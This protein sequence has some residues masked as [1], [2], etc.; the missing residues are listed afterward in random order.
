MCFKGTCETAQPVGLT[1]GLML[2]TDEILKSANREPVFIPLLG[3]MLNT[4]LPQ[5]KETSKS[6]TKFNFKTLE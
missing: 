6:S 1:L 3:D 4:I 2:D 5:V